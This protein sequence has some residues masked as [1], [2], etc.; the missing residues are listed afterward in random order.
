MEKNREVRVEFVSFDPKSEKATIRIVDWENQSSEYML[1][2]SSS[3]T[4]FL[5]AANLIEVNQKLDK[6]LENVEKPIYVSSREPSITK[7]NDKTMNPLEYA[8]IA[9]ITLLGGIVAFVLGCVIFWG[10]MWW[11]IL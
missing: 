10:I 4:V 8:Y 11:L 5:E 2:Y 6:I 3:L 9:V 1:G 7:L